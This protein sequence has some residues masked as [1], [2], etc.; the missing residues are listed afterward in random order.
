MDEKGEQKWKKIKKT[1]K[2]AF[3]AQ[4]E[5][6]LHGR[7]RRMNRKKDEQNRKAERLVEAQLGR[8]LVKK[9]AMFPDFDW[10]HLFKVSP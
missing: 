10:W 5:W 8:L 9:V 3:E 6:L 4:L 1:R 2:G 7:Y